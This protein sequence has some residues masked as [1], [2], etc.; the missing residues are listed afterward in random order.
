MPDQPTY[1]VIGHPIAHSLSPLMHNAAL[2]ALGLPGSYK[3]LN[4]QQ[5]ELA[6]FFA[7]M[8]KGAIQGCNITLPHKVMAMQYVD[9]VT[10]QARLAGA[11]NTVFWKDGRLVGENTD[12]I[13]F[14]AA[15]QGRTFQHALI[16]GAGGVSRAAIVAL[17]N[18]NVA[19]ISI[20]NRTWS[21]AQDMAE[22]FGIEAVPWEERHDTDCDLAVN[23]TSLG[24]TGGQEAMSPVSSGFFAGRSGFAYDIIYT[25]AKTCFLQQAETAGWGTDNGL[26]MFVEQGRASFRLW[27]GCSMPAD[28]AYACLAEALGR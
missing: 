13:G 7:S 25:P 18:M 26:S 27:T 11:I 16:L 4:L 17:K 28:T 3:A 12:V 19:Q 5:E 14:A 24:M 10:P 9:E 21:R 15:M 8:R 20:S 6:D 1:C 2:R 23:A 22:E